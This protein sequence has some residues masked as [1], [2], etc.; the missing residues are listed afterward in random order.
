MELHQI[1]RVK[2]SNGSQLKVLYSIP[3]QLLKL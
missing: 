3:N 1:Q 2:V